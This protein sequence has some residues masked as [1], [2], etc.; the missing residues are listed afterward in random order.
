MNPILRRDF[1]RR[2]TALTGSL[3]LAGLGSLATMR[4]ARAADYISARRLWLWEIAD[5]G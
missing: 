3:G 2:A 5:R 4:T 1:L